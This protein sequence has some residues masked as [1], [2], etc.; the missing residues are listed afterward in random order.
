MLEIRVVLFV[1]LVFVVV[2]L[3]HDQIFKVLESNFNQQFKLQQI[4]QVIKYLEYYFNE[5]LITVE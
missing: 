3:K 1:V 5:Y 2:L 4:V